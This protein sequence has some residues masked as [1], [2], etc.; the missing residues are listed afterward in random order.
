MLREVKDI[1]LLEFEAFLLLDLDYFLL[2]S[3]DEE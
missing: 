1:Y 2:L 3:D